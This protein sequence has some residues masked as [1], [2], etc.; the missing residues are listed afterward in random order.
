MMSNY[1][2]Y[3]SPWKEM[4]ELYFQEFMMFFFPEIA[5]DIEWEFGY[6][7]LDKEL[8][9]VVRDAELGRRM[10]DKLV[11]V[12]RKSSRH[13]LWVFIHIEVQGLPDVAFEKRM[14][15]YN[16]RIF[17]R[18][19]QPVCSLAVLADER[20]NWKPTRFQYDIWGCQASLTFPTVK[21]LDYQAAD[22][23]QSVN[24][25]AMV[26]LAYLKALDTKKHPERRFDWKFRLYKLLYERG[27]DKQ[28]ILELTRF[29]D[30]VMV[31]PDELQLRFDETIT[32]YEEER[33]MQ[34]VTSFERIGMEKGRQQGIQQGIL[35]GIQQ[36]MQQGQEKG[37]LE[38]SR[39][40]VIDVLSVR[41][42]TL[43]PAILT[44]LFQ[45]HELGVLN[46]LLRQAVTIPSLKEFE[47]LLHQIAAQRE[48]PPTDRS[49]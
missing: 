1:A 19:D 48:T 28:D 43:P 14:Y 6:E 41:F 30:W 21:L 23:E 45:C 17:D 32:A 39:L 38:Q 44:W 20:Q 25:F 34:Y 49:A 5:A 2:D 12:T 11:K 8:Q 24:P 9:Q 7:F 4:L 10:A 40:A 37:Q 31:L 35:Q 33:R 46:A 22:L 16:Y 3:D 26:V 29:I 15:I 13:N 47:A 42:T 36:G 18:Y 27:Y